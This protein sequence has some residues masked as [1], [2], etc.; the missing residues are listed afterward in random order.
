MARPRIEF[1][2]REWAQLIGL[3]RIQCTQEEICGV[4]MVSADTLDRRIKE[5]GE[6]C[7]AELYKKH[8]S[9]GK[10]SLRR[11]QWKA[12][13]EKHNPTML[14]WLG[15]NVLDQ[16]DRQH[17]D[18]TSSDGSMSSPTRIVIEGAT[19]PDHGLGSNE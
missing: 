13:I 4:M 12:A 1:S 14:I 2:D 10:A 9:E 15:K 19:V 8:Q 3:I 16:T 11:A 18:N 7:F 17:V 6:G 5:R